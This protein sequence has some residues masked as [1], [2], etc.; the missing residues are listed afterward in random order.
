MSPRPVFEPARRVR[1]A[2][3]VPAVLALLAALPPAAPAAPAPGAPSFR[4][5]ATTRTVLKN[6]LTVIVLP[7]QRLPLVDFRMVVRAGSVADPAGKEGLA[8]LTAGLLTQGA[9]KRTAQEIAEAIDFVGGSLRATASAE[10][11]VVTC[12]VLEKDFATGLELFRDVIVSPTFAGEEFARKKEEALGAL[13]AS[14]DDPAAVADR[15]VRPFLMGDNPL[16]H[17]S[18]GWEASVQTIARED[19]AAFH[20]DRVTPDRAILAVVGDV[21]PKRTIKA[22]EDAFGDWKASKRKETPAYLP[23]SRNGGRRVRIV[24]K[25]EVTQTQV[26]MVCPAVARSHPDFYPITVA[27]V[28]LGS[29]FTS[30]L[31]DEIRVNRGLTYSI[32][33]RFEMFRNTGTF[34]ITTFTKNES[35]RPMVDAVLEVVRALQREGPSVE[36]LDKARRFITGLFPLGLQAPDA[37]AARVADVEFYGLE[38]DHL[39]RYAERIAAVSMDDV[40]RALSAYFCV[41][42]LDILVV[43]NPAVA[44]PALEG[45]GALDVEEIR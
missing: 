16:G 18:D 43:S 17:P 41:D 2:A 5:P 6:G 27:N 30:R 9:G 37:L 1:A 33:S 8:G 42:D 11:V 21:D 7:T 26:R 19:V 24:S 14:R 45:L 32:R 20:A 3:L 31:V 29:G 12:E 44:R 15:A 40:R 23:L 39:D 10:Q 35:I 38:Q 4:L 13:A 25:P 28:I 22:I 34:G 36:E